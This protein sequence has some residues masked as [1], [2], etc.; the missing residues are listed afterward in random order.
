MFF[1]FQ[2]VFS[3]LATLITGLVAWSVY[4]YNKRDRKIELA[5][6]I[7]N[8]ILL[9]EKEINNIKKSKVVTDYSFILP[10]NH[11]NEAQHIFVKDFD[12]DELNKISE[13]FKA[14]SLAEESLKLIRSYLPI[15]MDQKTRVIQEKLVELADTT[16]DKAEY[17]TRKGKI[18]EVLHSEEYWFLPN[19]PSKKLIDFL[20]NVEQ[21]SLGSIGVKLKKIRDAKWYNF[22]V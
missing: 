11:W 22:K 18:L 6:I 17:E 19:A 1:F 13:F 21:L 10:S 8:D 3:G 20:Q 7:L 16:D 4:L 15:S 12:S 2:Y 14:C 9:A 5:T